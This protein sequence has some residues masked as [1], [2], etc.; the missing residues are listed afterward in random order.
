VKFL[1]FGLILLSFNTLACWKMQGTISVNEDKIVINQKIDHDK[2]YSFTGGKHLFHVKIPSRFEAPSTYKHKTG[3]HSIEIGVQHKK[4][5]TL[6]EV[7]NRKIIV[8]TGKE[9][10]IVKENTKTG[11]II[12]YIIKVTE[13]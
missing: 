5:I 8:E 4:G 2:I 3:I 10:Q 1:A 11:E 9:S 13:I 7:S 6:S 12:T